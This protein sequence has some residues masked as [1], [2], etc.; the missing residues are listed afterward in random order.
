M[1]ILV[2]EDEEELLDSISKHLREEEF[3]CE[4]ALDLRNARFRL[5]RETFDGFILDIGIPDGSGLEFVKEIKKEQPES[6]IIIISEKSSAAHKVEGLNIGADDYLTKPIDLSELNARVNSLLR[7]Y[8]PVDRKQVEFNEIKIKTDSYQVF[9]HDVEITLT[10]K[11]YDLLLYFITNKNRVIS[12]LAIVEHL[13]VNYQESNESFYFLY[14]H[15]KNLRKK[16]ATAGSNDYIQ[17]INRIGY[18]FRAN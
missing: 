13:W 10:K 2:I 9:V 3:Q 4:Y 11:E 17:N 16:L 8:K 5:N 1:K 18:K 14:T 7:R 6:F 15:I 12:K